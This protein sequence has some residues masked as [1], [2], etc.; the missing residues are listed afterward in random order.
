MKI[1][2]IMAMESGEM[3]DQQL[4][5]AYTEYGILLKR[6][7]R[8]NNPRYDVFEADVRNQFTALQMVMGFREL[9]LSFI[10]RR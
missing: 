7:E 3:T 5:E 9:P 4:V 1:E 10:D 8:M 2:T 6:I